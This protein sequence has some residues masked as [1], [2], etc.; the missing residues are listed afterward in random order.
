MKKLLKKVLLNKKEKIPT[1]D[2]VA[3][4]IARLTDPTDILYDENFAKSFEEEYANKQ[5]R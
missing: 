3:L 2:H 5:S 4:L 1:R